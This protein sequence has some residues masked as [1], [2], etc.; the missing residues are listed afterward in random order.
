MKLLEERKKAMN[1]LVG[2]ISQNHEKDI[3]SKCEAETVEIAMCEISAYGNGEKKSICLE[4]KEENISGSEKLKA[5]KKFE[6]KK[7]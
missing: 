6:N 2:I 5:G 7:H 3:A 1:E 4:H